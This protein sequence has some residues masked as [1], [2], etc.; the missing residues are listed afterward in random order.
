MDDLC[1]LKEWSI[2]DNLL[3]QIPTRIQKGIFWSDLDFTC[4]D[5]VPEFIAVGTNAGIVFWYNRKSRNISKL[6]C[7]VCGK[8]IFFFS[9]FYKWNK[10]FTVCF[11]SYMHKNCIVCWI[12]GCSRFRRWQ[13]MHISGNYVYTKK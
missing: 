8:I 6:R 3:D 5:V 1:S 10:Y 4:I 7:E 11:K 2:L 12:Y 9:I 13:D